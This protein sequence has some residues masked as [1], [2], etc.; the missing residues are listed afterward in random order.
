MR[1]VKDTSTAFTLGV[2]N[3]GGRDDMKQWE[4]LQ[5]LNPKTDDP[6]MRRKCP[7]CQTPFVWAYGYA[8]EV[9]YKGDEQVHIAYF[10][11]PLC[12]ISCIP[13]EMCWRT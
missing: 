6:G 3:S 9:Q 2:A 11:S 8:W 4:P 7:V 12:I 5:Y 1:A 13:V 10:C